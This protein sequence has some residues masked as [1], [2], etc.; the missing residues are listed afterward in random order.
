MN[1]QQSWRNQLL[2]LRV[3][4]MWLGVTWFYA[5]WHK[6][7][8]PGFLKAGSDS[9]IGTQL[10]AY[11]TTSPADFLLN[12]LI[13]QATLVG[14]L[15]I[16]SEFAIGA[17]TLLWIAPTWAAFGGLAMSVTLWIAGS[18]SVNPYFLGSDLAYAILWLSYFLFLYGSRRRKKVSLDRRGFLRVS[19]VAAL[20]LFGFGAGK[21]FASSKSGAS[22]TP[23]NVI[24][25]AEL[26]I[27]APFSFTA[28]S[29]EPAI[30]FRTKNGIFA[31]SA[32]CTHQGCT[33]QFDSAAKNLQCFCHG[34]IFDP[35]DGAKAVAGPVNKPLPQI[36]VAIEGDWIAEV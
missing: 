1:L 24:K 13:E 16:F 18:W 25:S 29:G 4:R 33:V 30:L 26:K 27:G 12:R 7:S 22:S 32:V 5:G 2:P 15:V 9:Y 23:V 6:A 17:A 3:M 8:D 10:S 14:L 19:S 35:Y 28:K 31:Y 20:S 21:L 36:S 34:A 11:V